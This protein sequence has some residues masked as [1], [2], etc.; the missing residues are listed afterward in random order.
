MNTALN[1]VVICSLSSRERVIERMFASNGSLLFLF[2]YQIG[3][4]SF[5]DD[6]FRVSM[7]TIYRSNFHMVLSLHKLS[8]KL[9]VIGILSQAMSCDGSVALVFIQADDFS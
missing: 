3:Y 2:S 8:S 4:L 5:G 9:V 7:L 1:Y 6:L